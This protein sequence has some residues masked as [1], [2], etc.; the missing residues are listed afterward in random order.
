MVPLH[1]A[2]ARQGQGA[3]Q[4]VISICGPAIVQMESQQIYPRRAAELL[5]VMAVSLNAIGEQAAALDCW[6]RAVARFDVYDYPRAAEIRDRIHDLDQPM[7]RD[8]QSGG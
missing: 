7:H 1:M 3:H 8:S 5:D 2:L 4:E 6:R